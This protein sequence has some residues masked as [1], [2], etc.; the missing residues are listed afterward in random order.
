MTATKMYSKHKH[1]S[2][3]G[4]ETKVSLKENLKG[5]AND[6]STENIHT[7]GIYISLSSSSLLS[8][9]EKQRKNIKD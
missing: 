4:K 6:A 8:G 5:N 7:L 9:K 3:F 1:F 2:S